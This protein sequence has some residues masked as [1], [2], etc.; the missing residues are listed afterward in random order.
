MIENPYKTGKNVP[1]KVKTTMR[2]F[3]ACSMRTIVFATLGLLAALSL[4]LHGRGDYH[5]ATSSTEG[6]PA[7]KLRGKG[8]QRKDE[9]EDAAATIS[10][11]TQA[12]TEAET[13]KQQT[14]PPTLRPVL[15]PSPT[16][17][18]R[19]T[20]APTGHPTSAARPPDIKRKPVEAESTV[21]PPKED[22][23]DVSEEKED[24]GKE[25]ETKVTITTGRAPTVAATS[26][27]RRD[28]PRPTPKVIVVDNQPEDSS[29]TEGGEDRAVRVVRGQAQDAEAEAE[30]AAAHA[31]MVHERE[32]ETSVVVQSDRDHDLPDTQQQPGVDADVAATSA[33]TGSEG[34]PNEHAPTPA[35]T[36]NPPV[37][38]VPP[39]KKPVRQ[40]MSKPT[41]ALAASEAA[42]KRALEGIRRAA[43]NKHIGDKA[44]KEAA[45]DGFID[46]EGLE[47]IEVADGG[48]HEQQSLGPVHRV[49]DGPPAYDPTAPLDCSGKTDPFIGV[50]VET[51]VPPANADLKSKVGKRTVLLVYSAY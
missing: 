49:E 27:Q 2:P 24:T 20:P 36:K 15:R 44:R 21:Q 47:P 43:A 31:A 28:V 45:A 11:K 9:S 22:D 32:E 46:I 19:P 39:A 25:E 7:S 35:P 29:T 10:R 38:V 3:L 30:E 14:H 26:A 18:A 48:N 6:I 12:T 8:G 23:D 17:T 42:R 5:H 51:Y 4:Y 37:A 41:I 40:A 34:D 50:A 33:A 1:N 13:A 16:P